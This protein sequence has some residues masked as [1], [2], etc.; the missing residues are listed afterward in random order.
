MKL[1]PGGHVGRL[2]VWTE[3]AFRKLDSIFGTFTR[4]SDVKKGYH[5]PRPKMTNADL[6]RILR[7]EEILKA[8]VPK[9]TTAIVAK[10]QRHGNPLKNHTL[11]KK[12]NPY[13]TVIKR[14]GRVAAAKAQ[15]A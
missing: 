10:K 5:L 2:I 8:I 9:P 14:A 4:L 13:S 3:G 15:K 1:A 11:M 7:S 6:T 12:L